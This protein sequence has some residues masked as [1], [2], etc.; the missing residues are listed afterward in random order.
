MGACER[1]PNI[2][3]STSSGLF[4]INAINGISKVVSVFQDLMG[5]ELEEAGLECLREN[6]AGNLHLQR[7][8]LS[9]AI[10][11]Y[12][13]AL[14]LNYPPQ[15]RDLHTVVLIIISETRRTQTPIIV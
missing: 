3:V 10:E 4:E 2:R 11:S 12:D 14:A 5:V 7:K 15:V 6:L 8:E 13:R 9:L 1:G